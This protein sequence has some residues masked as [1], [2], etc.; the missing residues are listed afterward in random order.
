MTFIFDF[1][2]VIKHY[3]KSV[4]VTKRELKCATTHELSSKIN[5]Q[6]LD[7]AIEKLRNS[8]TKL[9]Q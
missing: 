6:R 7:S 5:E 8:S 2:K 4:I 3:F 1:K 9:L